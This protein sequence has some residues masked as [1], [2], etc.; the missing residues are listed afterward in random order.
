MSANEVPRAVIFTD[1]DGTLLDHR[2]Y[3]ASP[4]LPALRE[5]RAAGVPVV[6]CS[7]KTRAELVAW[8]RRLDVVGPLIA[9]NGGGV[10]LTGGGPLSACF[11]EELAGLPARS[12]GARYE[13]LRAALVEARESL[14][15]A[16]RGFGDMELAEVS[17]LT[18][19]SRAEAALARERDYDE[20]FLFEGQ[21]PTGPELDRVRSWL[22]A[23]GLR[24]V[25]GG[26]LW[27]LTGENDKGT[28]VRWL[29]S[30]WERTSGVCPHSLALGDS[31]NDL[32]MLAAADEGVLVAR[33]DGTHFAPAPE[34]VRRASGAGPAGW[35]EAVSDWLRRSPERRKNDG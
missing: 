32:P 8:Q 11:S 9:E 13:V 16:L 2:T 10:F 29:L 25:R 18:G 4:A 3:D 31:E 27:H 34:N 21:Q 5:A 30:A 28:A 35:G 15:F 22:A 24:I 12:F 26:R 6:L 1:L 7:S 33:P 17:E 23:K 19:L 20:P 14:Q